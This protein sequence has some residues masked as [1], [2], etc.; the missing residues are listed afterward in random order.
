MGTD[1]DDDLE[2]DQGKDG[3]T[4]LQKIVNDRVK[5]R[6]TVRNK[7]SR[8]AGTSSLSQRL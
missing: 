1:M 2:G 5:W 8:S 7:G 4:T 3:W 6:N